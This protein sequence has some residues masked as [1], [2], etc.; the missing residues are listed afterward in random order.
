MIGSG[1]IINEVLRDP[2]N[3]AKVYHLLLLAMSI[4]DFNTSFWYFLSTWPIPRSTAN[5]FAPS[6][7]RGSCTVQGFFIQ[8]GIAT[9]LYNAALAL[10]YLLIIRYQWKEKQVRKAEKFLHSV[11][12]LWASGTSLAALGMTLLNNANL[13]CWISSVPLSCTGSYRNN[14]VNDCERGN[15]AWIYRWAFFYAPL[16]A[17]IVCSG[18]WMLLTY[19]AVR[20]TEKASSKWKARPSTNDAAMSSAARKKKEKE[21]SDRKH[22]KQVASQAFY[23]LMAFFFSWLFGTLTRFIQ[24]TSGKTYYPIILLM[25]IFTPMQGFLNYLVYIRPRWLSYRKK[26]PDWNWF[27]AFA[28][29]FRGEFRRSR[30]DSGVPE[31][32]KKGKYFSALSRS[33]DAVRKSSVSRRSSNNDVSVSVVPEAEEHKE[34]E[35]YP[36]DVGDADK[37]VDVEN[38][39]NVRVIRSICSSDIIQDD[40]LGDGDNKTDEKAVQEQ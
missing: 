3:R 24:M 17:A 33:S 40:F 21:E 25:A 5:V 38:G 2:K 19:L 16:W 12:L 34:E 15:N 6:G 23:Y 1:L 4:V 28:M 36:E 10:Y 9:P 18:I 13:W 26:H 31:S 11:P 22:S 20:K 8:F 39:S 30:R 37:D 14:G 29:I 27:M 7:T 35:P 32:R